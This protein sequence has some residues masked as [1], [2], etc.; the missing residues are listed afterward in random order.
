LMPG[1]PPVP[2][3]SPIPFVISIT[4]AGQIKVLA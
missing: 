2:N 1:S 4:N 3:P